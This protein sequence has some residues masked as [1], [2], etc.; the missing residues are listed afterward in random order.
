MWSYLIDFRSEN[1]TRLHFQLPSLSL[2]DIAIAYVMSK[3]ILFIPYDPN[4][5]EPDDKIKQLELMDIKVDERN[6]RSEYREI[7]NKIELNT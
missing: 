3:N 6:K 1:F 7:S 5:V 4:E 2:V